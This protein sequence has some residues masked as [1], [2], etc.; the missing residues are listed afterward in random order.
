MRLSCLQFDVFYFRLNLT[1]VCLRKSEWN[2][3]QQQQQQQQWK[4]RNS[5]RC[6]KR[7][8]TSTYAA[9][10]DFA[11][12]LLKTEKLYRMICTKNDTRNCQVPGMWYEINHMMFMIDLTWC[13]MY[14]RNCQVCD[15]KSTTWCYSRGNKTP[16]S[17]KKQTSVY[18]MNE[19]SWR[20]RSR[21]ICTKN[22]TRNCQ[23]C[24]TWYEINHIM[25]LI[26]LTWCVMWH[27]VWYQDISRTK[28]RELPTLNKF[29]AICL[30]RE[31]KIADLGICHEWKM[32]AW[33]ITYDMH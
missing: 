6:R 3:K 25:F 9:V 27:E 22:D 17:K 5:R 24:D 31:W 13:E 2:M 8:R 19:N 18:L 32:L 20:D 29:G 16:E 11:G 26:D 23:V 15:T 21:M 7:E 1:D 4:R 14:T 33:S 30:N 12:Y 28:R 10:R